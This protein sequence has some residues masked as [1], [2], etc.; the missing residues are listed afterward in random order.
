MNSSTP[1]PHDLS[2]A[3]SADDHRATDSQGTNRSACLRK[4]HAICEEFEGQWHTP[5]PA[6]IESLVSCV[7][8]WER[9]VLLAWLIRA[10]VELRT[11]AGGEPQLAE[12]LERFP[13]DAATVQRAWLPEE[14]WEQLDFSA[15]MLTGN[16][17]CLPSSFGPYQVLGEI[18]RGGMGVVY[19]ARHATLQRTVALKVLLNGQFASDKDLRR[20]QQ[21]TQVVAALDHPGIVSIYEVGE[22]GGLHFF[23]MPLL[24]GGSL[25]DRIAA[26]PL[27][28]LSAAEIVETAARA[29]QSAHEHGVI[30]RDLKPR[31]ILFDRSGAVKVTDFGLAKWTT[32]SAQAEQASSHHIEQTQTGQLIGTPSY[33]A[34]E[35]AQGLSHQVTARTDVYALGAVLY[36]AVT[37]RPPYQAATPLDTIRQV[38]ENTVVAPRQMNALIPTDLETIILKCLAKHPS[39]RYESAQALAEDLRRYRHDQPIQARRENSIEWALR[40]CRRNPVRAA[41]LTTIATLLVLITVGTT[42]LSAWALHEEEL[43][44]ARLFDAKLA[45][46]KATSLG[47]R[48]GHRFRSLALLDEAHALARHLD[49]TPDQWRDLRNATIS[50]LAR[51]DLYPQY[52][53]MGHPEG[54]Q[55]LDF[56][57]ALK[58]YVRTTVDGACSVRRVADDHEIHYIPSPRPGVILTLAT[59]TRDARFVVVR[60]HDDAARP[61]AAVAVIYRIDGQQ[62][63]PVLTRDNV[64]SIDF[65]KQDQTIAM[66]DQGGDM[67]RY[68]LADGEEIEPRMR[69]NGLKREVFVALHP[70]KEVVAVGSY[71]SQVV[72][73]RSLQDGSV[74]QRIETANG[75]SHVAWHPDGSLLALSEGDTPMIRLFDGESFAE[76]GTI[77]AYGGGMRLFFSHSGDYLATLEWGRAVRVWDI[78]SQQNLFTATQS[79]SSEFVRFSTDDQRIAGFVDGD[80]VVICDSSYGRE[81]RTLVAPALK[82]SDS[83]WSV[84]VSSDGRFVATATA[85]GVTLCDLHSDVPA[86]FFPVADPIA[87]YFEPATEETADELGRQSLL[88]SDPTGTYRLPIRMPAGES[89]KIRVGPAESTALPPVGVLTSTN[90]GKTLVSCVRPVGI[91]GAWGGIWI[92]DSDQPSSLRHW[93]PGTDVW[94]V[95]ASPDGKWLV[96]AETEWSNGKLWDL[97]TG[98]VVR[99]LDFSLY[100]PSFSQDGRFLLA[101]DNPGYLVDTRTWE[102]VRRFDRFGV[103]DSRGELAALPTA[104]NAVRIV[105]LRSGQDVLTCDNARGETPYALQFSP[106]SRHLITMDPQRG[107]SAWNLPLLREQLVRRGLDSRQLG[108]LGLVADAGTRQRAAGFEFDLEDWGV[109]RRQTLARN[110]DLAIEKG[111]HQVVRWMD[112]GEFRRRS[113]DDLGALQDWREAYRLAEGS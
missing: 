27:S 50:A 73:I 110:H 25:A 71:Y 28:P 32:E 101:G 30:H 22:I 78:A 31:N 56:D 62:V 8:G 4:L 94:S 2:D 72:L 24:D 92:V 89:E 6:T 13:Q 15:T 91:H 103:M 29:V 58:T 86:A 96:T 1:T 3:S 112:R 65:G 108:T 49:T 53:W 74:V 45:E 47:P 11:D 113:G 88:V 54:T 90:G 55:S 107:V 41:M 37:G 82:A 7:E 68:H 43:A 5:L 51:S 52:R 59:L 97:Q 42:L 76:R 80:D 60:Y 81:Y 23:S 69:A 14:M 12:F 64:V 105:E 99:A 26:G 83:Y 102:V 66:V 104:E 36:A 19:R 79:A 77:P 44:R 75:C 95:A 10:E 18:A 48:P 20:F 87:I 111:P 84:S 61:R 100:R 16:W 21:E 39:D 93:L 109:L 33:M 35:Q 85:L 70:T 63:I 57:D 46:A 34:P 17:H 67:A 98:Q 9:D 106:D 38:L 40:W